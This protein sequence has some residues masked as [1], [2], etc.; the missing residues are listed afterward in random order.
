MRIFQKWI[1][2]TAAFFRENVLL[3]AAA[4]LLMF[5]EHGKH[6]FTTNSL[7]DT[8]DVIF[9]RESTLNWL[10]IGRRRAGKVMYPGQTGAAPGTG[11]IDN[12]RCMGTAWGYFPAELHR[13]HEK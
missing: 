9:S 1:E 12:Y 5:F 4:F 13:R 8:D 6:A 2:E 11:F 10:E 7:F 3:C